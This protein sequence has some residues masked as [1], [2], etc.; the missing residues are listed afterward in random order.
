MTTITDP[1]A[2]AGVLVDADGVEYAVNAQRAAR[3]LFE[4]QRAARQALAS[5]DWPQMLRR[6][7][8]DALTQAMPDH[9]ARRAATFEAARPHPDD[10]NGRATP[11]DL[12][13]ADRRC[14]ATAQS[15]R[16]HALVLRG[17][18]G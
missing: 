16:D 17:V 3:S 12:A 7:L 10:Y 18:I 9:H 14:A 1:W 15:C 4:G 13:E 11:A 2:P 5:I 8:Q 6:F